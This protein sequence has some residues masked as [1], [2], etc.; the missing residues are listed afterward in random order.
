MKDIIKGWVVVP[1]LFVLVLPFLLLATF[2]G[3][4]KC[5]QCHKTVHVL[6][7]K[8]YRL[9]QFDIVF[10]VC[11]DCFRFLTEEAD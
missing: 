6:Q 11:E 1:I 7:T 10:R 2:L 9:K 5:W 4:M 8:R 3:F